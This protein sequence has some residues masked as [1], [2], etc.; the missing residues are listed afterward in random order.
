MTRRIGPVLAVLL[1]TLLSWAC[2]GARGAD[3]PVTRPTRDVD[4]TYRLPVAG[5]VL[6]ERMRWLVARQELRVDPPAPDLFMVVDY[7][8]RRMWV[9]DTATRQFLELSA[10]AAHLPGPA[11][12]GHF[13][14]RGTADVAGLP[15]TEWQTADS[16]GRQVLACLTADGV[17]LRAR[18]VAG[19]HTLVEAERVSYAPQDPALFRVPAGYTKVTPRA[20]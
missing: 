17:L 8:T 14:R 12:E 20:K 15:C 7:A 16:A 1:A 2:P 3:R 4:V 13:V 10:R 6:H 9:I 19:G 18:T 11:P 5:H